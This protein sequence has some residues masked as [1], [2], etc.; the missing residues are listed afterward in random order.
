VQRLHA[1]VE[2]MKGA[3]INLDDTRPGMERGP[4]NDSLFCLAVLSQKEAI[5]DDWWILLERGVGSK[6]ISDY[7]YA[8]ALQMAV[9]GGKKA[10]ADNLA[11]ELRRRAVKSNDAVYWQIAGFS[12]WGDNTIEI[13]AA[14]LSALIAY[15]INDLLIPGIIVHFQTTKRGDHWISTKDTAS[16]LFALC[17]FVRAA[18]NST[19]ASGSIAYSTNGGKETTVKLDGPHSLIG[20]LSADNLKTGDNVIAIRGGRGTEGALVRA[21]V[22]F[23][24]DKA[25]IPARDHGVKVERT[26]YL[27]DKDGKWTVLKSGATVPKGS[28]IK[29]RTEM[30]ATDGGALTYTLLESPKPACGETIP[31]NDKRFLSDLEKKG[32]VLR[33][34]RESMTCYHYENAHNGATADFVFLTEF[35]GE[36]RL[37]PAR[38]ERMYS[39]TNGGHSDSF[40]LKVGK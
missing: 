15:D 38:V 34:D 26:I 4:I 7:G 17:D 39:P 27:R 37:P 1:Y 31:A 12:N 6:R 36:F 24:R 30:R 2:Q 16:V 33:E 40:V 35:S 32:Y 29:V 23:I 25:D 19:T 14:A 9:R 3:W 22:T 11:L 5:S 28:F 21:V 10:L 8:L 13:T 20:H 18:K